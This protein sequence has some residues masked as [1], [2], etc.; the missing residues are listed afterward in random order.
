MFKISI[1]ILS[2][3]GSDAIVRDVARIPV[4]GDL[5]AD[6]DGRSAWEVK[7]VFLLTGLIQHGTPVAIVRVK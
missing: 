1:E 5:I 2:K 4:A 6:A 3:P 7:V